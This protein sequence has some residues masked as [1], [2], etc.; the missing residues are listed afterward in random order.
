MVD[1]WATRILHTKLDFIPSMKKLDFDEIR[2]TLSPVHGE[3]SKRVDVIKFKPE[4]YRMRVSQV[5]ILMSLIV[6]SWSNDEVIIDERL[7]KKNKL[8]S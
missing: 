1:N 3:I 6:S 2:F 7:C 8:I 4:S 5:L